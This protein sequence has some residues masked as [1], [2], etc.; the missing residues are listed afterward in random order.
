MFFVDI[1]KYN[2]IYLTKQCFLRFC[3]S[4]Q[5]SINQEAILAISFVCI[6]TVLTSKFKNYFLWYCMMHEAEGVMSFMSREHLLLHTGEDTIHDPKI[7]KKNL[8]PKDKRKNFWFYHKWHI[9]IVLVVLVFAAFLSKDFFNRVNPDYEIGLLTKTSFP[10]DA[11]NQL[12]EALAE[13]AVD[14]N[15]DGQVI[16]RVNQYVIVPGSGE[17]LT[18]DGQ[19]ASAPAEGSA[20]ASSSMEG[21]EASSQY[22]DAN[23]QMASMVKFSV[24]TQDDQSI[25]FWSQRIVS[26]ISRIATIFL[27]N[28]IIPARIWNP[29]IPATLAYRGRSFLIWTV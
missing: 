11:V 28:L 23:M 24:D 26:I 8:S 4:C 5:D 15:N 7:E 13:K 12:Q 10:E 21:Q 14:R 1:E 27:L 20:S 16:V 9:V 25:I 3:S 6:V 2:V 18:S 17:E 22:V 19:A 29:A